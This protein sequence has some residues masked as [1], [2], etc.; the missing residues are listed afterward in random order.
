MPLPQEN[1]GH[2]TTLSSSRPANPATI[3]LTMDIPTRNRLLKDYRTQVASGASTMIAT[4]AV[5]P[6]ENL[7]TRMQT[8]DFKGYGHCARYIWR[9]EGFRGYTAGALPPL[10]SITLV[11]VINFSVYQKTKYAVSNAIE[12]ATGVS[13]LVAYNTPGSLPSLGTIT[14]FTVAGMAAGLA[15]APLA[16]PFELTKNVV[17]TS[18]L[19]SNRSHASVGAAAANSS[20]R[21][22]PRL[23][24]LQAIKRIVSRHG[25]SGLYTGIRL[26]ALRDTVGTG[27]YFAIYETTKQLVSTY[28]GD[29]GLPFGGPMIAGALCGVIPWVCTYR[30]DTLKTRAQSVL[31]GK[32]REINEATAA[33]ARSSMYKGMSVVLLRT[34]VQNMILLSTFEYFKTKIN[35]LE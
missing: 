12:R 8:H 29:G 20:L 5:T 35:A 6:L 33:V 23:G 10:A 19:I 18:V 26:H 16:C 31:L 13:P 25:F 2:V 4:L 1:A 22:V 32:S 17:Q 24:T 7:K 28:H 14:T 9:T 3:P 11:R 34:G 30:L 27:M 21:D 15:A